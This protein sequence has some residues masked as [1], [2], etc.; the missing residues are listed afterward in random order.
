M[1]LYEK[2][3]PKRFEDVLGQDKAVA[4]IKTLLARSCLPY[5]LKT[6]VISLKL[7]I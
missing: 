2:Y 6:A 1:N 5:S 4:K 3:R 7:R